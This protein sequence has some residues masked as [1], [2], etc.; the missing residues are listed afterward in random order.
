MDVSP[1]IEEALMPFF[2]RC[3]FAL[4]F[5]LSAMSPATLR[6]AELMPDFSQVPT[7]WVTDR[8]APHAFTNVGTIFGRNNVLGIEINVAEG[9]SNRDSAFSSA[10]YNTQGKQH[11]IAGGAVS[12]LSADLYLPES[13]SDEENGSIRTD[14]WGVMTNGSSVS[15]YPIIGFTNIGGIARFRVW[16]EES[17]NG[18]VDLTEIPSYNTWTNLAI[19]FSGSSFVYSINGDVVYTDSTINSSTGF[20]AV[21]MQAYN[22]YDTSLTGVN[23]V[24]YTA[25]WDNTT[26]VPL[27]AAVWLMG[28]ALFGLLRCR[29]Y[30]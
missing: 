15:S 3:C 16:D 2:S 29:R 14:M 21:I 20:Q 13:W 30:R 24:D 4:L 18:W 27:P 1:V 12:T 11:L 22:F 9:V 28:P 19:A 6:A 23:A 10:F 17:E 7:D 5:L 25:H 8:Y 26:P